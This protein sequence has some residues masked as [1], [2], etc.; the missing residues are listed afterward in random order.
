VAVETLSL[1]EVGERASRVLDEV[2]RAI[3]GKREQLELILLGVLG[4]GHVLLEDYP[5]L[6]KTLIARSFAQATTLQFSRNQFTPDLMPTDV[7]GSSIFNQRTSEFEFRAGPI[8]TN[9]LLADE[10]NR[11]PPK[12]QAALLEAMQE[13]QVTI[14]GRTNPLDRPFLVLATQNPIEY[15]G[16]YPLPEAQLDRFLLRS[17]IG[18]PAREDEWQVLAR[19]IEREVDEIELTPVVDGETLLQMQRAL[20]TVHVSH[21]VGLYMVDLV[22]AT[23]TS[24]RSQVGSSPRGT[25]ALLKLSRGKAAL[26]GRDFVTPDDVKAVAV[27]ALA[28][29]LTLRPEL[30]V[31]RVTG[32][33][34]VREALES[35]PTPRADA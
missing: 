28:H 9:L 34:V 24:T 14:E 5:G 18:Y 16:T 32:D 13:R 3:V 1:Q 25:L 8:F 23:R 6:A 4:D 33:D 21:E 22:T 29:R 20:E 17:T 31:Q 26:Q 12:T 30:W 10:I 2:E 35:V 11:A 7:T 27:P 15:E 19:R